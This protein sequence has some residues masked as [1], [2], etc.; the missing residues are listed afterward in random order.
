MIGDSISTQ[1][2]QEV[3]A[4]LDKARFVSPSVCSPLVQFCESVCHYFDQ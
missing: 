1:N 3:G 4:K 2:K